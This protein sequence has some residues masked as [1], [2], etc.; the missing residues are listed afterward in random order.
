[1]ATPHTQRPQQGQVIILFALFLT[2]LLAMGALLY[3]GAEALVLRRQLQNAGDAAALA[4]ANLMVNNGGLCTSSRV[5]STGSSGSNDLYLAAKSSIQADLGWSDAQVSSNMTL[6]CPSDANYYSHA[7]GVTLTSAGAHYFNPVGLNVGT[8]SVAMNGLTGHGDFSVSLLDPSNPLWGANRRGCPSFLING[9]VT[10]TFEGSIVINSA[11]TRAQNTNAAMKAANSAFTMNVLNDAGIKVVGEIANGTATYI[12]PAPI[13]HWLPRPRDPLDGLLPP[14]NALD[15]TSGCLGTSSPTNP[16][17]LPVVNMATSGTGICKS[18][19]PCIL[20]PGTYTG[21]IAAGGGGAPNTVLLRPGVYYLRGGGITLKS[22]SARIFSIPA[23][24]AT[25]GYTNAQ[26]KS[27]FN[28]AQNSAGNL[29]ASQMWIS[30]CPTPTVTNPQSATCGVLLYNAPNGSSWNTNQDQVKVGA[31]GVF[32]IRA[33]NPDQDTIPG[34]QALFQPY[35]NISIWQ[36][37]NPAPTGSGQTQPDL[38][39]NGGACVTLSGTVYAPGGNINFG[40]GTCGAG[41]GDDKLTMQ[42]I[43]WDLTLSGNNNFY[44]QYQKDWFAQP[45]TYGL[46][47]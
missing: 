44:F 40:G 32:Q 14:C 2:S 6:S 27:D 21:G 24:N 7:V 22:A 1:M 18:Q 25:S 43:C 38:L 5:S 4:A 34:N 46:V 8:S 23:G 42:F 26:A 16:P 11:C 29:L 39:M 20:T 17:S 10:V 35:R 9:G 12:T 36:A 47:Q 41:G 3:T 15:G 33:Y 13:E 45:T 19:E 31:Q 30:K 28:I 37:A